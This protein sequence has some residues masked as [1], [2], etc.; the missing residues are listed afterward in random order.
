MFFS[1]KRIYSLFLLSGGPLCGILSSLSEV[2]AP[3][4]PIES[5]LAGSWPSSAVAFFSSCCLLPVVVPQRRAVSRHPLLHPPLC[6]HP[7]ILLPL[8][9]P[10]RQN[11]HLLPPQNQHLRQR[12]RLHQR[13]HLSSMW[14]LHP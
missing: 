2:P 12:N 9:P 1:K 4:I 7:Q 10:L 11:P 8:R 6:L 13:R 14:H 5:T 3:Q